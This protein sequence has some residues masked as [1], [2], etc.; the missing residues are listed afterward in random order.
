MQSANTT[1][2]KRGNAATTTTIAPQ[3]QPD[4]IY[5]FNQVNDPT[6]SNVFDYSGN[7]YMDPSQGLDDGSLGDPS[8][9]YTAPLNGVQYTDYGSTGAP[10]QTSTELVK[11][12]RN[13]DL[14]R[15]TPQEQWGQYGDPSN[16][17][18]DE[19][20][21]ELE[22]RVAAAKRD[23]QG[24]RKQIPP[25]VQKLSRYAK[26]DRLILRTHAMH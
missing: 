26:T 23:A 6:Y 12:T 19:D 16:Q 22:R 14:A 18:D 13:Q 4:P 3:P 7:G 9:S 8:N 21:Q 11:R 24:K 10:T 25:F 1:T 20:E 17:T 2:R 15:A 5:D